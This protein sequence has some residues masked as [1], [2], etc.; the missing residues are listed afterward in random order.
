MGWN[1]EQGGGGLWVVRCPVW[2]RRIKAC[3]LEC[4][5]WRLRSG[6]CAHS[7]KGVDIGRIC[8][9]SGVCVGGAGS[10]VCM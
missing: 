1:V 2:S 8:M 3:W 9:C 10:G 7:R 4:S 5:T 6:G